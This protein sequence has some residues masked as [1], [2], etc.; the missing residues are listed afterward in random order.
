MTRSADGLFASF[1]I[2]VEGITEALLL[3]GFGHVWAAGGA[4][5]TISSAR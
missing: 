2:V 4:A 1:P 5:V 3:R